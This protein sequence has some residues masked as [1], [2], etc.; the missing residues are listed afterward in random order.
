LEC[1]TLLLDGAASPAYLRRAVEALAGIIPGA[2][3][4]TLARQSHNAPDMDAPG[5]V[6]RELLGFYS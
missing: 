4:T 6:A 3:R 5:G 1:R 2:A